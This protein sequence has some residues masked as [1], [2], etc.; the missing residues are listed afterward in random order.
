MFHPIHISPNEIYVSL[1][2]CYKAIFHTYSNG[3]FTNIFVHTKAALWR[4]GCKFA[5]NK[6]FL[7]FQENSLF[8]WV[9]EKMFF[10]CICHRFCENNHF[11]RKSI[12]HPLPTHPRS[13]GPGNGPPLMRYF[14][15]YLKITWSCPCSGWLFYPQV[16]GNLRV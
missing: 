14:C 1:I 12:A 16:Y 2:P 7:V 9:S 15:I 8:L 6:L 13:N 3:T 4:K 10:F 11:P 5:R